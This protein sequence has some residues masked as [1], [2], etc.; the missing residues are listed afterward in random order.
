MTDTTALAALYALAF[1]DTR[2]WS[3]EEFDALLARPGAVFA[4]SPEGYAVGHIV[5]DEAELLSIAIHPNHRREG[6][7]TKLLSDFERAAGAKGAKRLFLEVSEANTAAITL[8][9]THG[10]SESGRRK[11]YYPSGQD[12][13]LMEKRL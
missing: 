5:L 7:G 1:P 13:I 12:A 11:G 8:Y 4:N 2:A 10:W 9:S 3:A 6:I